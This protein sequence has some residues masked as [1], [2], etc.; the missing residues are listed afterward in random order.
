MSS[1]KYRTNTESSTLTTTGSKQ[2]LPYVSGVYVYN[3][4]YK[5]FDKLKNREYFDKNKQNMVI[6]VYRYNYQI[7]DYEPVYIEKPFD[8]CF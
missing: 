4:F 5:R 8:L 6:K 3:P 7:N 1:C 2:I